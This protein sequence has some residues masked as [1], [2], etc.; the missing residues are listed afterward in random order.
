MKTQLT[1][2]RKAEEMARALRIE[3]E[4]LALAGKARQ[5]RVME[6]A[7]MLPRESL[8]RLYA[9]LQPSKEG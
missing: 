4:T 5:S 9:A 2:E 6:E 3:A 7:A 1:F 8:V